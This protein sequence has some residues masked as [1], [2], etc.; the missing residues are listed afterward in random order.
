MMLSDAFGSGLGDA[1]DGGKPALLLTAI[2]GHAIAAWCRD[3]F[4]DE[5]FSFSPAALRRLAPDVAGF[6]AWVIGRLSVHMA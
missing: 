5:V 3:A 4:R 2:P 6:L 1:L